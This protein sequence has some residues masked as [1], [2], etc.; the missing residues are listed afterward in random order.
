MKG[1]ALL[2]DSIREAIDGK[3]FLILI[4]LSILGMILVGSVGFIP[5]D[6]ATAINSM[7]RNTNLIV[8]RQGP[9]MSSQSYLSQ[10]EISQ[11]EALASNASN[12]PVRSKYRFL[13]TFSDSKTLLGT[14]MQRSVIAWLKPQNQTVVGTAD[15]TRDQVKAFIESQL[16]QM[17]SMDVTELSVE[18]FSDTETS[19]RVTFDPRGDKRGW[20]HRYSVL[21]GAFK[22]DQPIP[23]GQA[24]NFLE[25]GLV[26]G[27]GSWVILLAGVVVTS[28]FIPNML[29]KGSIDLLLCKPLGR[30]QLLIFKY[31]GGLTFVLI[32]TMIALGGAWFILGMRTGIWSSGLVL[33]VLSIT[34]Y[35]AILYAVSTLMS[36]LTRSAVASMMITLGFWFT[37]FILGVVTS[38]LNI[39]KKAPNASQSI[40][41]IVFDI[42]DA[43][44]R[45]TPRTKDLNYLTSNLI[46]ADMM[47][48]AQRANDPSSLVDTPQ[49]GEVLAVSGAYILLCLGLA[50]W[51]FSRRD[52]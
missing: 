48:E 34:Y 14:N 19:I 31:L 20:P 2:K 52:F 8:S 25:T 15:V 39:A 51:R 24:L 3:I 9:Q 4:G 49:W 38:F 41:P 47:T 50:S 33:A 28:F 30:V 6:P 45:V 12:D 26:S 21:F 35:F 32:A 37:L 27:M 1:F 7:S 10:P 16:R 18:S 17:A 36:V 40:S 11:I 46:S 22:I 43:V 44:N 29:R 13:M 42:S 5:T 23:L